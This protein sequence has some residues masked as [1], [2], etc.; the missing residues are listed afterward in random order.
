MEEAP[1]VSLTAPSA[2]SPKARIVRRTGFQAPYSRDQYVSC[3]G[4]IFSAVAL[5]GSL[6]ALASQADA[7][8][9]ANSLATQETAIIVALGV[10]V[11][12]TGLLLY[13]WYSCEACDPGDQETTD[14]PWLGFVL[15]GPRWEKSKYCAVCRKTIPG[16]DHHCTWLNTC[17]GKRNYA[18]FFTIAL[19]GVVQFLVQCSITLL[20]LAAWN[21]WRVAYGLASPV[22]LAVQIGLA[23]CAIVSVPCLIMYTTLLVFHV[24]LAW[25]GYGTYDYYL[26][27]RDA[28]R[29]KRR[30]QQSAT[31]ELTH[32]PTPV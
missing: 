5:Y 31:I 12:V 18:Q 8:T 13:A 27:Q 25:L 30:S 22:A 2:E 14:T 23:V 19:C 17:V 7:R 4:H 20:L 32:K 10:H 28:Q 3:A 16:M 15:S 6:A 24:Y 1:T 29:A 26:K 11:L 21:D 9:L